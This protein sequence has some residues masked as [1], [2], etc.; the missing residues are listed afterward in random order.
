METTGALPGPGVPGPLDFSDITMNSLN[1]SWSPPEEPNGV[2][3]GYLVNYET[4]DLDIG[5]KGFL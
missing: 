3:T 5:E 4:A 1:V 2:I